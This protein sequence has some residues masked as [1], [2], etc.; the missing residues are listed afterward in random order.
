MHVFM[1]ALDYQVPYLVPG[2]MY[3]NCIVAMSHGLF[4]VVP[5]HSYQVPVVTS[6]VA[7]FSLRIASYILVHVLTQ[8][9]QHHPYV[10]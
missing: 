1:H 2:T 9:K 7:S 3:L 8:H 4:Y 6:G 5:Q 10:V